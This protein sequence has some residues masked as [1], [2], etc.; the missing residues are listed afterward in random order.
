[1]EKYMRWEKNHKSLTNVLSS[2]LNL[3]VHSENVCVPP[4]I[5]AKNAT[6]LMGKQNLLG[7]NAKALKYNFCPHLISP[8]PFR[9]SISMSISNS[10]SLLIKVKS[11]PRWSKYILMN[12]KTS[13]IKAG[14]CIRKLNRVSVDF[15]PHA[16]KSSD[17]L[18]QTNLCGSLSVVKGSPK[19][20]GQVGG[21][22]GAPEE[23]CR[24]GNPWQCDF[25]FCLSTKS[26]CQEPS[27]PQLQL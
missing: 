1:M 5:F 25:Q 16:N 9:G 23:L 21:V 17:S 10:H 19:S 14:T 22:G 11:F 18:I 15:K 4:R 6:F 12:N 26:R 8:C 24:G 13:T 27:P 3:C 7:E 20:P 2:P